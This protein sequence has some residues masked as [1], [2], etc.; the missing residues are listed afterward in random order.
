MDDLV[1]ICTKL[2]R[3]MDVQGLDKIFDT[4]ESA[5]GAIE[6]ARPLLQRAVELVNEVRPHQMA[7]QGCLCWWW[8]LRG[9]Y[10]KPRGCGHWLVEVGGVWVGGGWVCLCGGEGG[11]AYDFAVVA[12]FCKAVI[13]P[14][15]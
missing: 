8:S 5:M 13:I 6:E 12:S 7:G 4:A 3:Q 9:M 15:P 11:G 14:L 10:E 1:Y 2:A